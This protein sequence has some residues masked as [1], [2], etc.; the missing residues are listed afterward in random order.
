VVGAGTQE[1][2]KHIAEVDAAPKIDFWD[3]VRPLTDDDKSKE[4][5]A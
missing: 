3:V 2:A 5:P 1:A 4:R